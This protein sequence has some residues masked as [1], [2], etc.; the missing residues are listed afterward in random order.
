M[1]NTK[2]DSF[3]IFI[4]LAFIAFCFWLFSDGVPFQNEVTIYNAFC[5]KG[6]IDNKCNSKEETAKA[7]TYKA[8]AEQNTMVH[9]ADGNPPTKYDNC[10]IRNAKNWTCRIEDYS[11]QMLDGEYSV[12]SSSIWFLPSPF[13]GISKWRWWILRIQE[14]ARSD[15]KIG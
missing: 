1:S 12:K 9:W 7:V 8:V 15:I 4:F 2:E 11:Y 6:R 14:Y 10:A 5:T 13:Y 3:G